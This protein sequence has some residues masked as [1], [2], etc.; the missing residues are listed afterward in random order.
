ML[1]SSSD[2]NV[3]YSIT[4]RNDKDWI[5]VGSSLVP[6]PMDT[7]FFDQDIKEKIVNHIQTWVSGREI[8][9]SRGLIYKTGI[10]LYGK[11]GTGKSSLATAIA[12]YLNCPLISIDTTTF[13]KLNIPE[14]VDAI[15]ADET[16]YVVL[17]DEIDTIFKSREDQDMT[18][19]QKANTAKL[20][21]FLDS[22]QSPTNVIFVATTNYYDR[23]DKA[24]TRK[25]RFDLVVKL[26]DLHKDA[27]IEMCRSFDLNESQINKVLEDAMP[28]DTVNPATLQSRILEELK[29]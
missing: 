15:N 20:L 24:L 14:V 22:Q 19:V 3:L 28:E 26:A 6:R 5:C 10:L 16:M 27:A 4:A 13:D 8:Y 11:A 12:T 9:T 17:I 1:S 7:L 2:Q 23:L 29:Q 25:G 18:E 21:S